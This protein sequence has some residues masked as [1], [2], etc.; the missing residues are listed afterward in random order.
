VSNEAACLVARER[1]LRNRRDGGNVGRVGSG[2][3]NM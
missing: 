3:E 1:V 2:L